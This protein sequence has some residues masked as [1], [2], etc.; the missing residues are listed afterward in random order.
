MG[1]NEEKTL[2]IYVSERNAQVKTSTSEPDCSKD[3][4]AE[5]ISTTPNATNP[6]SENIQFRDKS[7]GMLTKK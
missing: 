7:A 5:D 2:H 3:V 1:I 6:Q 4:P